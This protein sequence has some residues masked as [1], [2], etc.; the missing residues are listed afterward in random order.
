MNTMGTQLTC[1]YD[2][3]MLD[4]ELNILWAGFKPGVLRAGARNNFSHVQHDIAEF[5]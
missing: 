5:R 4:D 1:L 2:G 3:Q